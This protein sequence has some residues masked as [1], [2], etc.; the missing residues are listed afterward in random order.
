[1]DGPA[2]VLLSGSPQ[3]SKGAT[4]RLDA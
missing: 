2:S 4:I 3:G 1:M